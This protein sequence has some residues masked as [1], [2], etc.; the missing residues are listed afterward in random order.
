MEGVRSVW[1]LD[2]SGQRTSSD[3][4]HHAETYVG[5]VI[6]L[7][8]SREAAAPS[9]TGP[10]ISKPAILEQLDFSSAAC[11]GAHKAG[12]SEKTQFAFVNSA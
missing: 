8:K 7:L 1:V 9:E 5:Q 10:N 3:R 2:S 4:S 12:G 6:P 11:W